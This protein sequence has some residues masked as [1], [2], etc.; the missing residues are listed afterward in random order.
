M[1]PKESYAVDGRTYCEH[2]GNS[3][4]DMEI[5]D[6]ICYD[7]KH[8]EETEANRKADLRDYHYV[9]GEE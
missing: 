2:C 7:C 3:D 1:T 9:Y 5:E 4:A 8:P 6:T